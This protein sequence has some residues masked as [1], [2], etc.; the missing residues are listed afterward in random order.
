[1]RLANS[2]EFKTTLRYC[3]CEL[4]AYRHLLVLSL[5]LRSV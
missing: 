5:N 3:E 1:M 4:M 2:N